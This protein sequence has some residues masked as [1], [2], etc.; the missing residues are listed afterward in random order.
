MSGGCGSSPPKRNSSTGR[1]PQLGQIDRSAS[2][3]SRRALVGHRVIGGESAA[4]RTV[5]SARACVPVAISSAICSPPAGIA[6]NPHVPQPVVMH[7]A[8][9]AGEAHDRREVGGDVAAPGP[10][11]QDLQVAE[12]RQQVAHLRRAGLQELERR[13]QRVARSRS[14]SWPISICPRARLRD[15]GTGDSVDDTIGSERLCVPVGDERLQRM[16][17]HRQPQPGVRRRAG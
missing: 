6:L 12:E 13:L 4:V 5:R 7:Q 15:V 11:P 10:L 9:D 2:A 16:R 3:R 17:A 8:V 14:Y 1:G